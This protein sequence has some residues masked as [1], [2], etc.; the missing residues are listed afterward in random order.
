[1]KLRI[2]SL[3]VLAATTAFAAAPAIIAIIPSPSVQVTVSEDKSQVTVT[4]PV[5]AVGYITTPGA[6][7]PTGSGNDPNFAPYTT[8]NNARVAAKADIFP[9]RTTLL[10]LS[11]AED[12]TITSPSGFSFQ[13]VDGTNAID[14]KNSVAYTGPRTAGVLFHNI[15]SF[16]I[17]ARD[18]ECLRLH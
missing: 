3:I 14:M 9:N 7:G 17:C 11:T 1:M 2:L 5:N 16:Y 8:L 12:G 18:N 15:S 10:K 6:Q 13:T 4:Q